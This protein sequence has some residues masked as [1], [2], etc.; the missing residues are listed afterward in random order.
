VSGAGFR[1]PPELTLF[2][3][4]VVYLGDAVAR[5]APDMDVIAETSAAVLRVAARLG[6]A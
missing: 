4:N 2:L 1:A 5:H 3:K 6:A